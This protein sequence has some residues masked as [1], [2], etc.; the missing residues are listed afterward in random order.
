M[1]IHLSRGGKHSRTL[2]HARDSLQQ[3]RATACL[4]KRMWP[5]STTHDRMAGAIRSLPRFDGFRDASA[6][7]KPA[8]KNVCVGRAN[9][10]QQQSDRRA[11]TKTVVRRVLLFFIQ[12]LSGRGPKLITP[13]EAFTGMSDGEV[14][15]SA[16]QHR[17]ISWI[18]RPS[19]CDWYRQN[20]SLSSRNSAVRF[21]SFGVWCARHTRRL[22]L[23]FR[24]KSDPRRPKLSPLTIAEPGPW[25]GGA[26]TQHS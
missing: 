5:D 23:R 7:T 24:P 18:T 20:T 1:P 8:T 14:V 25:K 22:M 3:R 9:A 26:R 15:Q 2:R 13:V 12:G 6:N 17:I 4:H 10:S 11:E 21:F 16:A 19:G